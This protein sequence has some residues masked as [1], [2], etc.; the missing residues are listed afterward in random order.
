MHIYLSIYIYL[1]SISS[2]EGDGVLRPGRKT[3]SLLIVFATSVSESSLLPFSLWE[4][5]QK[6]S[7]Q[8]FA[9]PMAA[10][11]GSWNDSPVF[12][13]PHFGAFSAVLAPFL[14]GDALSAPVCV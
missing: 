12:L 2:A 5:E 1:K 10:K 13:K 11:R 4:T 14:P 8:V 3:A 9:V 7:F 6:Q